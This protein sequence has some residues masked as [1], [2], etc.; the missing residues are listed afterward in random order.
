MVQGFNVSKNPKLD[1]ECMMA[2]MSAKYQNVVVHK[3]DDLV[4]CEIDDE[5]HLRRAEGLVV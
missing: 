1:Y 3:I 4:W 2:T 5:S